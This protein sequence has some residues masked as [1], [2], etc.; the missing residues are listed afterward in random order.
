M[1]SNGV[2]INDSFDVTILFT[3]NDSY[4]ASLT[5]GVGSRY[6]CF[7]DFYVLGEFESLES[8]DAQFVIGWR[9][10]GLSVN[11]I[12]KLSWTFKVLPK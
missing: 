7:S 6:L 5:C 4:S 1:C 3:G 10:D 11:T 9:V 2:N 12:T 8:C